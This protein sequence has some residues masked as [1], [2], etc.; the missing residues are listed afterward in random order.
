MAKAIQAINTLQSG[1]LATHEAH[2]P[3]SQ[4][5]ANGLI[6]ATGVRFTGGR[7]THANGVGPFSPHLFRTDFVPY[8]DGGTYIRNTNATLADSVSTLSSDLASSTS[9]S[10]DDRL[11]KLITQQYHLSRIGTEEDTTHLYSGRPDKFLDGV[12]S[13]GSLIC[14]STSDVIYLANDISY[15][16]AIKYIDPTT[17]NPRWGILG[18]TRRY[19]SD[20]VVFGNISG[21]LPSTVTDEYTICNG[22]EK[23]SRKSGR[24]SSSGQMTW[25]EN[26]EVSPVVFTIKKGWYNPF[27]NIS[28]YLVGKLGMFTPSAEF[29]PVDRKTYN[30]FSDS[31]QFTNL[32]TADTIQL[33][34]GYEGIFVVRWATTSEDQI[35]YDSSSPTSD[36]LVQSLY[37]EYTLKQA[38]ASTSTRRFY[39]TTARNK[40]VKLRRCGVAQFVDTLSSTQTNGER[41]FYVGFTKLATSTGS[42]LAMTIDTSTT[43]DT[44]QYMVY[45]G[46]KPLW[47]EPVY[48]GVFAG[49]SD[50]EF[51]ISN[52]QLAKS[53]SVQRISSVGSGAGT[54][55]YIDVATS[56]YGITYFLTKRGVA[57]LNFSTE[58]NS[59]IPS[60]VDMV[61]MGFKKPVSICSSKS[62]DCVLVH[63]YDGTIVQMS[64]ETG[65]FSTI[66]VASPDTESVKYQ[67]IGLATEDGEAK[68]VWLSE[69]G[70]YVQAFLS[71][72]TSLA[73]TVVTTAFSNQPNSNV[74]FNKVILSLSNSFGGKVGVYGNDLVDIPYT[75]D[76]IA[77]RSFTGIKTVIINDLIS[78]PGEE[79]SIQVEFESNNDMN[80][81]YIG[82]EGEA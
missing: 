57:H 34:T 62:L 56:L 82:I 45:L 73:S 38:T 1:Q 44:T 28:M 30:M 51:L 49:T 75:A 54:T 2:N 36:S 6:K 22:F 27:S 60:V 47:V 20:I 40:V 74:K 76:E 71:D 81:S 19:F 33:P 37:N 8:P 39:F 23:V 14:S 61:D 17:L 16:R 9:E 18:K 12:S 68:F 35:A 50:G 7:A 29:T 52:E 11:K 48:Q 80:I 46:S 58:R 32:T 43:D 21:G 65:A 64:P 10:L 41:D 69:S 63:C 67:F 13:A 59:Y 3:S 15:V 5:Y 77:A 79:K 78:R 66:S 72:Q 42:G 70:S 31:Y 25:T 24:S 26:L 4:K 55:D 53:Y